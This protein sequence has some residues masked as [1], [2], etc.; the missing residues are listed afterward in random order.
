M[1][2][3]PCVKY[4]KVGR[5]YD[6]PPMTPVDRDPPETLAGPVCWLWW[7]AESPE[8]RRALLEEMAS[9]S[10]QSRPADAAASRAM[11][12]AGQV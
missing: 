6:I 1:R 5:L 9:E 7:A 4:L 11:A 10:G 2:H 8:R 12:E 3:A